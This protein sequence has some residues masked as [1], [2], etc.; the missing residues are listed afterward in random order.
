MAL[1]TES[2][3]YY[4]PESWKT[5]IA[6]ATTSTMELFHRYFTEGWI[7]C[8]WNATANH[9]QNYCL[10]IHQRHNSVSIFQ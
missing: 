2:I 6:Y 5:F 4:V 3:C 10:Y 1:L 9:Q 7:K 8:I